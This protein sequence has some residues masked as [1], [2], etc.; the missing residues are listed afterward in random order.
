M[1]NCMPSVLSY[2]DLGVVVCWSWLLALV[3]KDLIPLL[4]LRQR[5]VSWRPNP[6]L[7]LRDQKPAIEASLVR[8][9]LHLALSERQDFVSQRQSRQPRIRELP[10]VA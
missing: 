2:H 6:S 9:S 8:N 5:W 3:G 4:L 1:L 10:K 7:S